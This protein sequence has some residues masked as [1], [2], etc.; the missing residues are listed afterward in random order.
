MSLNNDITQAITAFVDEQYQNLSKK[1][2]NKLGKMHK[3][4]YEDKTLNLFKMILY[5]WN[6]GSV[7]KFYYDDEFCHYYCINQTSK[8]GCSRK[9]CNLLHLKS[10][11]DYIDLDNVT[12]G[13][14]TNIS[15]EHR[16]TRIICLYLLYLGQY[17]KNPYLLTNY[18]T[19]LMDIGTDK[20]EWMLSSKCFQRALELMDGNGDEN[21]HHNYATL[22]DEK[23]QDFENAEKH[24]KISLDANPDSSITNFNFAMFLADSQNKYQQSIEYFEK[25]CKLD[26]TNCVYYFGK[27]LSLYELNQCEEGIKSFAIA[28]DLNENYL[29]FVKKIEMKNDDT[30]LLSDSDIEEAKTKMNQLSDRLAKQVELVCL[31]INMYYIFNLVTFCIVFGIL[32][33]VCNMIIQHGVACH[34]CVARY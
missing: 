19:S 13:D 7:F 1:Y 14:T 23:L 5:N 29:K 9:P 21:T 27:G 34:V 32:Q 15:K 31:T 30:W 11:Q 12:L 28:L 33:I 25:A 2:L 16:A 3:R 22:L 26:E 8:H 4:G 17:T 24:Y 10:V 18:A 6:L 20:N